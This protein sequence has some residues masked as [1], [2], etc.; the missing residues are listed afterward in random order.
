MVKRNRQNKTKEKEFLPSEKQIKFA[1]L[2]L[3]LHRN[4][5]QDQIAKCIGVARSTIYLWFD[6]RDFVKWLN[7]RAELLIEDTLAPIYKTAIRK[8]VGGDFK[9]A[10]MLLEIQGKYVPPQ[11]NV[12]L[13]TPEPLKIVIVDIEDE[14]GV[15]ELKALQGE[16][17]E[18]L[19]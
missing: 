7:K 2:Y 1:N 12:N 10:K 3:D 14:K 17:E 18:D 11:L 5:T 8:A 6:N 4:L 9:Y 16:T 19:D 15:Q 13:K